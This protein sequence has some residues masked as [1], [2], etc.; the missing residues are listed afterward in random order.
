MLIV[1]YDI[2]FTKEEHIYVPNMPHLRSMRRYGHYR[3][4][5]GMFWK[6]NWI[7][8]SRQELADGASG[9]RSRS[10][11]VVCARCPGARAR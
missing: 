5:E 2:P 6:R 9:R 7:A 3:A 11:H 8:V 4:A 1:S 10:G